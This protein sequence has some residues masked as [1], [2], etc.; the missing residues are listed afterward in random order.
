MRSAR[1]IAT[2][3]AVLVAVAAAVTIHGADP[4][5]RL[6]ATPVLVELFTSPG[7][8]SC[9]PADELLRTMRNDPALRGHLTHLAFHFHY[10]DHLW[11]RDP[12]ASKTL[13]QRQLEY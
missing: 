6:G 8:S 1:V 5:V 3:I 13:A 10:L 9:P 7:C 4:P 11:W 12:F 2:S